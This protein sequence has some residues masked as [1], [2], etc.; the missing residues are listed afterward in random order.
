MFI[1]HET[2]SKYLQSILENG[3]L[4]S[5]Y[6]FSGQGSNKFKLTKD[7]RSF[8]SKDFDSVDAVYFRIFKNETDIKPHF[9]GDLMIFLKTSC[10]QKLKW[11]FNSTENHGF[12]LDRFSPFSGDEGRT[13]FSYKSILKENFDCQDAELVVMDNISVDCIKKI[14]KW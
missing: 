4:T 12:Y 13:L 8:Q 6:G 2:N 3:L 14:L 7:P 11:H 10:L 1:V 9:G 5:S